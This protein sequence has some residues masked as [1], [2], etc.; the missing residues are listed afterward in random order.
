MEDM[1]VTLLVS[2]LLKF[3]LLR[4][5]QPENMEDVFVPMT[6]PFS[7]LRFSMVPVF[8]CTFSIL[9]VYVIPSIVALAGT[10]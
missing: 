1:V 5:L 2:K 6:T 3:K 10:V 9:V 8:N 4:L 7:K